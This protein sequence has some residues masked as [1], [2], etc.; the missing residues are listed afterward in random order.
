MWFWKPKPLSRREREISDSIRALKTLRVEDGRISIAPSE[1]LDQ[2]GYIEERAAAGALLRHGRSP[3]G[4]DSRSL[5][6]L[7]GADVERMVS[8]IGRHL[9]IAAQA[10]LT[11]NETA[12][13]LARVLIKGQKNG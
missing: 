5:C 7:E 8:I 4:D 2:P 13:S 11:I 1:V 12:A 6:C 10:G 3:A 9:V